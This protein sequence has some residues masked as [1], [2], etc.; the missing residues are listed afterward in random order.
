MN[1]PTVKYGFPNSSV[2][3][4]A[5]TLGNPDVGKP[6]AA[7]HNN[8]LAMINSLG[9]GSGKSLPISETKGIIINAATI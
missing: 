5:V 1:V 4:M 7:E 2:I 9:C 3:Q 6:M 8:T